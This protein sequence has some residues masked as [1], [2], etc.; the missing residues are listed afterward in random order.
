MKYIHYRSGYKYQLAA[1]F[2]IVVDV[3]PTEPIETEFIRLE[4]DGTLFIR[5][6]YAWDG[7]SGPTIDTKKTFMRGSVVHDAL[8]QLI[9]FKKLPPETRE[10]ADIAL[11]QICREDGM[12]K[13]RAWYVFRS[14][15]RLAGFAADPANKKRVFIVP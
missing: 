12:C 6:G 8:Y 11:H 15:R 2:S 13:L 7:P 3:H 14:V 10:Q 5:S 1:D 4:P 9:R